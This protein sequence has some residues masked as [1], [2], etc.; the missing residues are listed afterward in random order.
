MSNQP[1]KRPEIVFVARQGGACVEA[2]VWANEHQRDG[3]SVISRSVT[4]RKQYYDADAQRWVDTTTFY[5]SDLPLIQVV[6]DQAYRHI[7]LQE[8][9][10]AGSSAEP[11]CAA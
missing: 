2:A 7:V 5:A 9:E 3:R 11:E 4:V 10:P 8:R 1:P 6:T